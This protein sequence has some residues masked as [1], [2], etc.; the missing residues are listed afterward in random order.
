MI[1]FKNASLRKKRW[2]CFYHFCL[3]KVVWINMY[4][5]GDLE[6]KCDKR[7]AYFVED[8]DFE[9]LVEK[10]Y[11]QDYSYQADEEVHD[12][13]KVYLNIDGKLDSW[14]EE[15]LESFKED[16]YESYVS[17]A[18]LQDLCRQGIIEPGN[19]VINAN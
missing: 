15:Q 14:E 17:R 3:A 2:K 6:L 9:K 19:Y 18:L 1:F 16:G 5:I 13:S 10:V 12:V 4:D 11:D 7:E 8:W